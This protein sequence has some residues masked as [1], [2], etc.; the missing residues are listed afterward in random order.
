[1]PLP[2]SAAMRVCRAVPWRGEKKCARDWACGVVGRAR[3]PSRPCTIRRRPCESGGD[4]NW[5]FVSA[6]TRAW[7]NSS[8]GSSPGRASSWGDVRRRGVGWLSRCRNGVRACLPARI[9]V[10][11]QRTGSETPCRRHIRKNGGTRQPYFFSWLHQAGPSH[12]CGWRAL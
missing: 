11:N 1:M 6:G 12:S 4:V 2:V 7:A 3:S 5:V 8:A 10:E 9:P